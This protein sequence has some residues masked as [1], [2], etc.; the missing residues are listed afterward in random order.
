MKKLRYILLLSFIFTQLIMSAQ[1]EIQG[2][3]RPRFE[4]RNGYSKLRNDTTSPAAFV[5]QRSRLNINY[6][7]EKIQLRFSFFDFRVWGDQIWKK[8]IS[9]VGL[10]EAWAKFSINDYWSVKLGRQW[11]KYDNSRLIS[12]VNWNQIGAA[13][14]AAV[15]YFRKNDWILDIGSAWNQSAQNKFGTFYDNYDTYYKSLNFLW[16]SKKFGHF[17]LS[18]LNIV[19]GM[20]DSNNAD[21][22]NFRS[23]N[24]INLNY[25]ND[26]LEIMTRLYGQSGK[27]KNGQKV[28]AFYI[29][30]DINF[31]INKSLNIILG[32]E[33]KSGNNALDSTNT[34][35]K[36]FDIVY[37]GRHKFNG[38]IDYFSTPATTKNAGL[39]DSYLKS[40]YILSKNTRLFAEYHYFLLQN[41]YLQD[42][43]VIDKFLGH[44]VDFVLK[45]SIDKNIKLETGYSF[46]IGSK[47]LDIIKS[48]NSDLWN[49]W[50]YLMIT[51]NPT[52]FNSKN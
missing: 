25:K 11:L 28:E 4:Y 35:S 39:I 49:N 43:I 41:N 7:S 3:I 36:A 26:K 30:L 31:A 21:V 19:D 10:N 45:H 34:I 22:I 20:Q 33:I 24:G 32:N 9:S 2:I 46:I 5:S 29:N 51:I 23:T 37:G 18:S 47:S 42:G 17:T 14:D 50:F 40:D 1:F 48:G 6:K 44:E 52:L 27:L 16:F 38:R 12:P 8:D 13:H 15:I